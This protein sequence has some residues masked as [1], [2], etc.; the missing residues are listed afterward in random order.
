MVVTVITTILSSG[1]L[2]GGHGVCGSAQKIHLTE[3]VL[4]VLLLP[5]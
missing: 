5:H 2:A 1:T 4:P 3:S